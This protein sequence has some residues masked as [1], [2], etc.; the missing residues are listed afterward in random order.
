V[1]KQ[2]LVDDIARRGALR[3]LTD[4]S[5]YP[6][7]LDAAATYFSTQGQ[8]DPL[9]GWFPPAV[10]N[11][12]GYGYVAQQTGF[13]IVT[14]RGAYTSGKDRIYEVE[15]EV[16]QVAVGGGETPIVK[17]GCWA[18][19]SAFTDT[20]G[21]NFTSVD[22]APL[23]AGQL[24]VYRQRFGAAANVARGVMAWQDTATCAW[25]RLGVV[26]NIDPAFASFPNSIA[27]IRRVKV[28]DVTSLVASEQARADQDD[29]LYAIASR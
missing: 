13:M 10:T 17:V 5:A 7:R 2:V 27:R 3:A 9:T 6:E 11:V 19:T 20:S 26:A 15:T 22:S 21:A 4:S 1:T 29:W 25:L 12:A 24:S 18:L 28:T 14:T 8:G 23:I 16:E